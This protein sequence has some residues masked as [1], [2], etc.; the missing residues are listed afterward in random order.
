MTNL[1][2]LNSRSF[3]PT[4]LP[5]QA[6]KDA[7][8][9]S[10]DKTSLVEKAKN[11]LVSLSKNG[12]DLQQR[13]ESLG[14]STVD[15]AQ[16]LIG[17]FA[18]QLFGDAAKDATISFDS[19]SLDTSAS[20]A[21]GIQHSEGAGGVTDAAALSLSESSHFIGKGTITTADGRKFDFE[22]EVQYDYS[23]EAAASKSTSAGAAPGKSGEAPRSAADPLP[24]VKFPDIHFPGSLQ[25]LFRL[26]DKP[27]KTDVVEQGQG[28]EHGQKLGTLS[29]RLLNLVDNKGPQD[30]YHPSDRSKAVANA[31]G[32]EALPATPGALAEAQADA[33]AG[34]AAAPATDAAAPAAAPA[35][36]PTPAAA[37]SPE[38]TA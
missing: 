14:N 1:S 36:E 13:V 15:L 16:N 11:D 3:L 19:I 29:M 4:A 10:V 5:A 38:K 32:K 8:P 20:Y 27:L 37:E 17:S 21:A 25:D 2:P 34:D 26:F 33:V 12:I 18:Q 23:L 9:A 6:D 7:R 24:E 35:A 31:Y 30:I 28:D 22:V